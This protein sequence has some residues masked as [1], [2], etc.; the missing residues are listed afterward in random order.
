MLCLP[1]LSPSITFLNG[2]FEKLHGIEFVYEDSEK[3]VDLLIGFDLYWSFI[4]GNIVKVWG[5]RRF[6]YS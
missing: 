1:K 4:T 3:D 5:I 6:G 2:Q